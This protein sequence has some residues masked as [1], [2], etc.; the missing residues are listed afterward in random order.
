ML[1]FSG[2]SISGKWQ[3]STRPTSGRRAG[4]HADS[5]LD[6]A[7]LGKFEENCAE[8]KFACNIVPLAALLSI[9]LKSSVTSKVLQSFP[10][11][12]AAAIFS[13]SVCRPLAVPL[14][15]TFLGVRDRRSWKAKVSLPPPSW[16][17]KRIEIINLVSGS[18]R[19]LLKVSAAFLLGNLSFTEP[20][21]YIL[22]SLPMV[23]SL[24][25]PTSPP[26]RRSNKNSGSPQA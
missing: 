26:W 10:P 19:T 13:R 6:N 25:G 2:H 1:S 4:G 15:L 24:T 12:D 23:L 16:R 7:M 8:A 9:I 11:R 5:R 17:E 20:C 21:P 14:I 18:R 3:P 22:G